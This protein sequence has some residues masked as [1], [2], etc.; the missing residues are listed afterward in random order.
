MKNMKRILGT[1]AIM[2]MAVMFCMADDCDG[3]ASPQCTTATDCSTSEA[4]PFPVCNLKT[5]QCE[6]NE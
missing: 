1:V 5:N 4:C 6:C 3:P 2:T